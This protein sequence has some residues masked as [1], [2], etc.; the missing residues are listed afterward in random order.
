[1][2]DLSHHGVEEQSTLYLPTF[3]LG[4]SMPRTKSGTSESQG[5]NCAKD[6]S[7]AQ[8]APA[9]SVIIPASLVILYV[10]ITDGFA[11]RICN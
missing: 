4:H 1:M 11:S 8:D 7:P 5:Q 9:F 2:H 3:V 10:L 6:G